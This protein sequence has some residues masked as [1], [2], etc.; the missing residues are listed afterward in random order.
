MLD[1]RGFLTVSALLPSLPLAM[2]AS[3]DPSFPGLIVRESEPQNLE[4]PFAAL[5]KPVIPQEHFY[6]RNH[7]A[8]PTIDLDSWRLRIEGHIDK[9]VALSFDEVL[10]LPAVTKMLTME[11]AG[12]GRVY[13]VPKAKGVAWQLGA[14]GSAAW[15]GVPLNALLGTAGVKAGAVEVILAGADRGTVNEDP[16]SPGPIAFARSLPLEKAKKAEVL[17][18]YQ[19]NGEPLT[20]AHGYPLRAVVG[21]WY[22][23]ASVKWLTK[24]IVTD[25]PFAG[26]WQTMDYTIFERR[27]GLPVMSPITAMLVKS[28]IAR[29]LA[30]EVVGAGSAYRIRGA[31]WSGESPVLKIE[32]STDAGKTWAEAKWDQGPDAFAWRLWHF[33]WPPAAKGKHALMA[34]ATDA[35]GRTQPLQRDP[36]RRTYCVNHVIPVEIEVR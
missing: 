15:T 21:G 33:D 34:R 27:H 12:N 2:M 24:I 36:D 29:P 13:L 16:K 9:P 19:I 23:M 26:F 28:S 1:R 11:C 25:R 8:V 14:V 17:L 31:A 35:A 18:A 3:D 4:Y 5:N 7:F 30:G 22:G 10:K 32:V 20:P 6:V